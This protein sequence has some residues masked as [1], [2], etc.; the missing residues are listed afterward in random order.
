MPGG[1]IPDAEETGMIVPHGVRVLGEA[2]RQAREWRDRFPE[3]SAIS[4][5]VNLSMRQLLEPDLVPRVAEVLS[6]TRLDHGQLILE[7]TEG[8]LLQ[9]VGETAEKLGALKELGARLALDDFGT[10]SSSLGH[11]RHFPIDV[12]KIDKSFVDGLGDQGS[13]ASALVRAIIELARTL[14]LTTVGEGIESADQLT[15]LQLAGCDLGQGYLFARPL[16][17]EGLESMLRTGDV[18]LPSALEVPSHFP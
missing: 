14:R 7:I 1:F 15:Q 17:R 18:F 8:S 3:T 2:C 9:D 6:E 10:G 4:M 5:S 13:E 11:L 16:A 12:L